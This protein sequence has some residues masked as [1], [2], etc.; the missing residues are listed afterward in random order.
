MLIVI[1]YSECAYL[2]FNIYVGSPYI[3]KLIECHV[4]NEFASGCYKALWSIIAINS[5]TV[6][7]ILLNDFSL[8]Y[9][10]ELFMSLRVK[11]LYFVR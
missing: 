7:Y 6:T 4:E 11:W 1:F 8:I 10:W 2:L 3:A 5:I 9:W